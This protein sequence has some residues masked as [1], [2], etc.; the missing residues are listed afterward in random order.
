MEL[1]VYNRVPGIISLDL[2]FGSIFTRSTIIRGDNTIVIIDTGI[3][4]SHKYIRDTILEESKSRDSRFILVNTHEH[5][6]HI[7]SNFSLQQEFSCVSIAHMEAVP[8]MRDHMAQFYNLL[9]KFPESWGFTQA[10]I[11]NFLSQMD[12]KTFPTIIFSG[13]LAIDLGNRVLEIIETPG[14]TKGS[15]SIWD[16]E[17]GTLITG[18]SIGWK[19]VNNALPQ[20][21]NVEDY[22]SSIEKIIALEPSYLI[23]GHF[24]ILENKKEIKSFL[25]ESHSYVYKIEELV[26]EGTKKG[27]T[28]LREI[29]EYVCKKLN[30]KLTPQGLITINAHL[31]NKGVLQCQKL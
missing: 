19:G 13:N 22:I 29:A 10:D 20:Y 5:Y 28:S 18:D 15:C 4:E 21:E 27:L 7:G 23:T 1:R 2:P 31:A 3:K 14:H 24:S 12:E 26:S 30:A 9:G 6:D 8:F 17:T 25:E 11:A 16:K